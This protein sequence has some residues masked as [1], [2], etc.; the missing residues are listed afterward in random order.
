M[1]HRLFL[2]FLTA[3]LPMTAIAQQVPA[4]DT[5]DIRAT[6]MP[7]GYVSMQG[8]GKLPVL[9]DDTIKLNPKEQKAVSLANQWKNKAAMP[10]IGEDGAVSF[11]F[12]VTLPSVVCAPLYACDVGLQPGEIVN[13]VDVG[14]SPRWKVTP[15]SSGIGKNAITHLI[16]KPADVGLTSN[17]IVNTDRRTYNIRLVSKKDGWMP[18]VSFS[19][20]EDTDAAW[21]AYHQTHSQK[22]SPNATVFQESNTLASGELDFNYRLKGDNPRWK[23]VRVYA[24]ASKTFI[25]FPAN[26]QNHE[27]PALVIL[28]PGNQDQLVNYRMVGNRYVVDRVI[29]KAALISGV[30]R[31][32]SRVEIQREGS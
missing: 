13:Q 9:S 2:A 12:G 4:L 32:Q 29:D 5:S 15:A 28:G 1:K 30:G 18:L 19:Y 3:S 24:N 10:V 27:I 17:M 25:Q 31:N 6:Y 21:E 7:T 11:P 8:Y 14:D 22:G 20:P 16:I 23:P 26:A